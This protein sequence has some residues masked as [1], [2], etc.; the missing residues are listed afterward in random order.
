MV[1]NLPGPDTLLLRWEIMD[2][3]ELKILLNVMALRV[4][5]RRYLCLDVACLVM[6]EIANELE[7][8]YEDLFDFLDV[9]L[10]LHVWVVLGEVW[11]QYSLKL[12]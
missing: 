6:E 11:E 12:K 4:Q 3:S 8:L 1:F 5:R 10:L 7:I 9:H 2:I